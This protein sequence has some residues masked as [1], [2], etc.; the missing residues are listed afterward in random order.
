MS[1][2]QIKEM[3]KQIIA[4]LKQE[5]KQTGLLL[6]GSGLKILTRPG[7]NIKKKNYQQ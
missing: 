3:R 7:K 1:K 4:E 2:A 5:I 6:G